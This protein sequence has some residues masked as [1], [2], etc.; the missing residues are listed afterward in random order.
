M[1]VVVRQKRKALKRLEVVVTK[2][3]AI[4]QKA[5]VKAAMSHHLRCPRNPPHLG[6]PQETKEMVLPTQ[7]T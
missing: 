1:A 6:N 2:I 3:I 5:V 4:K 7:G